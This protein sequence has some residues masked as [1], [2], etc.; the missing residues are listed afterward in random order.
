MVLHR[1]HKG[2]VTHVFDIQAANKGCNRQAV[3]D[4]VERTMFG[5]SFR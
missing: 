5:D 1:L 4:T 2:K 3:I